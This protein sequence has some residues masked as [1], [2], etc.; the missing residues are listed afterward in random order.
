MEPDTCPFEKNCDKDQL[1]LLILADTIVGLYFLSGI[2]LITK[3]SKKQLEIKFLPLCQVISI[4]LNCLFWIASTFT[5][6]ESQKEE[7]KSNKEELEAL[8]INAIG[9]VVGG[10]LLFLCWAKSYSEQSDWF[11]GIL[12]ICNIFLIIAVYVGKHSPLITKIIASIFNVLMY[13]SLLQNPLL[14]YLKQSYQQGSLP[15]LQLIV[16]LLSSFVWIIYGVLTCKPE[17]SIT[18]SI[19][20]FFLIAIL[21]FCIKIKKEFKKNERLG[22]DSIISEG[23]VSQSQIETDTQGE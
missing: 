14:I 13:L 16:G 6:T 2:V 7:I 1:I 17:V 3:H 15:F 9:L 22:L 10:I 4:L 21:I 8:I 18:N 20:L 12:N 23:I 11:I 19:G 5:Y